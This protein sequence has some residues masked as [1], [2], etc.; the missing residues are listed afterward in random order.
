MTFAVLVCFSVM[1]LVAIALVL[2]LTGNA[3]A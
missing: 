1:F 2:M 3:S